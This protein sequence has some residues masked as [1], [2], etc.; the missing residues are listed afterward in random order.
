[1]ASDHLGEQHLDFGLH[2]GKAGLDIGL[3]CA[4]VT[5]SFNK[6][7]GSS[8]ASQKWP[9]GREKLCVQSSSDRTLW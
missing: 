5:S 1:M 2:L 6:K 9:S 7:A 8:P 4:H 3:D